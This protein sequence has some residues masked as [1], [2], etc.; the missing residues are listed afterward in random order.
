MDINELV[1]SSLKN[2]HCYEGPIWTI[3]NADKYAAKSSD[4]AD[5]DRLISED[6]A[7]DDVLE[8]GGAESS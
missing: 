6:S 1:V 8:S 2:H 4:L 7:A 3:E 5:R